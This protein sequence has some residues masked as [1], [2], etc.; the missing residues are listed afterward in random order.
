MKSNIFKAYV[1]RLICSPV[2]YL[3]IIGV[4]FTCSIRLFNIMNFTGMTV[5]GTI[6]SL[7]NIDAFR[8]IIPIFA[9][10]PF[11]SNYCNELNSGLSTFCI[12][13]C[14]PK[15]YIFSNAAVCFLS[16]FFTALL[17]ILLFMFVL[18]FK[19]P[20]YEFDPNPKIMPFGIFLDNGL[21]MLYMLAHLTIY[22]FSVSMWVS[23]GLAMSA[24]LPNSFIAICTPFIMSY[25]LEKITIDFPVYLNLWILSLGKDVLNKGPLVT[26]LYCVS[27]F[28]LLTI[29]FIWIFYTT[30]KRR[31]NNE[32]H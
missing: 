25:I 19:I 23:T 30:A 22:S 18:S 7:F 15:K 20:F 29:F 6:E 2:L 32:L 3:S 8:K 21:P 5:V 31:I 16:S 26:L 9:A 17:G 1:L 28:I 12:I 14:N 4:A 27:V 24:L 13:R 11:A 10:I